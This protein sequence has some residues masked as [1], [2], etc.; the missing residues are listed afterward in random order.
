[1]FLYIIGKEASNQV[2]QEKFQY[3][4]HTVSSVFHK[5]SISL[6]HLYVET[7]NLS[8]KDNILHPQIAED[9]KYFSYFQ[10]YLDALD[11]IYIPAHIS[12]TNGAT[13]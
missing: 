8:T 3:S 2:V 4:G 13:Y 5:V 9:T 7:V 12:A 10:D 11:G 6:F 1:M